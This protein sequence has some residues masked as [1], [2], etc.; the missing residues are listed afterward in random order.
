MHADKL[1]IEDHDRIRGLL[2]Q[3]D[4]SGSDPRQRRRLLNALGD[5]LVVHVHIEDELFYPAV[6]AVSPLVAIALA[7]HRQIDDH[8]AATL[9]TDPASLRF[10]EEMGALHAAIG[11]H[12][13][14]EEDEMFPQS[15]A[16]GNVELERLGK[17][18][19]DRQE[20]LRRSKLLR[21]RVGIKRGIL[22]HT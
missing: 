6:R 18:M 21:L 1:L 8:M 14:E 19:R 17:E 2:K 4:D 13:G 9:R 20:R 22:R 3:L 10:A 5:E 11:G 16:L 12:A 7:E 15:Q